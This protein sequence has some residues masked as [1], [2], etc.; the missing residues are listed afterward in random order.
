MW[1]I[2]QEQISED[3]V[4]SMTIF[5]T[6]KMSSCKRFTNNWSW[7]LTWIQKS[8]MRFGVV[9]VYRKG[10]GVLSYL[11]IIS[12]TLSIFPNIS[13]FIVKFGKIRENSEKIVPAL[14][15]S[16][17]VTSFMYANI[18]LTKASF[19]LL[20]GCNLGF[21]KMSIGTT[22]NYHERVILH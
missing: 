15:P 4:T 12:Q 8:L 21:P 17:K 13:Q 19:S 20:S 18:R 9:Y 7:V 11:F 10:R 5:K 1:A 3:N 14:T 22:G 6:E 2:L 16:W